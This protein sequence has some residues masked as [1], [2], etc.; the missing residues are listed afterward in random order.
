MATFEDKVFEIFHRQTNLSRHFEILVPKIFN[1]SSTS[2]FRRMQKLP[3]DEVPASL[4]LLYDIAFLDYFYEEINDWL[5]PWI[6]D[7]Y[8]TD[9]SQAELGEM[10]AQAQSHRDFYE[11]LEVQPGLGS[12]LSSLMT[13]KEYFL[14]DISSSHRLTKWDLFLTRCYAWQGEYLATGS[15][16]MLSP[17]NRL[18]I[19]DRL[20]EEFQQY[21][22]NFQDADYAHFAKD[23]WHVFIDIEQQILQKSVERKILTRFGEYNRQDV[24]FTV[25]NLTAALEKLAALPEFEF[26]EQVEKKDRKNKQKIMPQYH[27]DWLSAGQEKELE[28]IHHVYS[29]GIV[30]AVHQLDIDG[31]RTGIEVL[32]HFIVDRYLARLTV[33]SLELAEYAKTRIAKLLGNTVTFKRLSKSPPS[34]RKTEPEEPIDDKIKEKLA[35]TFFEEYYATILDESIPALNNLTPRQARQNPK[36]LPLLIQWLK[37]FE[38]RELKLKKQGRAFVDMNIFKKELDVDF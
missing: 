20:T 22:K 23:C 25:H 30:T 16:T 26:T 31:N 12:R 27:F 3:A 29:D 11:V 13:G 1:E 10:A 32:G 35:E 18:Y 33:N 4:T 7:N 21:Q 8:A 5:F 14:N 19:V 6:I 15:A 24:L 37:D 2:F 38:N 9:F 17:E 36:T 34:D 28:K